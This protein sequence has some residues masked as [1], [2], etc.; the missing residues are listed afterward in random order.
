MSQTVCSLPINL[1][2]FPVDETE[3]M[4]I[5]IFYDENSFTESKLHHEK[6]SDRSQQQRTIS[7]LSHFSFLSRRCLVQN[8][9]VYYNLLVVVISKQVKVNARK[10]KRRTSF[11]KRFQPLVYDRFTAR[12]HQQKFPVIWRGADEQ[13]CS[14][15]IQFVTISAALTFQQSNQNHYESV[16]NQLN[17]YSET[18]FSVQ[19]MI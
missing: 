3:N 9:P 17:K 10:G 19:N 11:F 18:Y 16:K 12:C 4:Q 7:L 2:A 1:R 8:L 5:Y 14:V 13:W 15:G 6:V